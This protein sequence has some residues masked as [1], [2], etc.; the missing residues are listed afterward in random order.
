M[1]NDGLLASIFWV[2]AVFCWTLLAY[3]W[4]DNAKAAMVAALGPALFATGFAIFLTV[5]AVLS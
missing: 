3:G 1:V 4:K 5:K 2:A